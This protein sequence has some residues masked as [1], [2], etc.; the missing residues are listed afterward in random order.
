MICD[1]CIHKELCKT[2]E[3]EHF[4]GADECYFYDK[5]KH[6]HWELQEINEDH[7]Y[8]WVCSECE[9]RNDSLDK[10]NFCPNCGADMRGELNDSD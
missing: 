2:A 1:R 4:Y 5:I 3:F 9:G 6:G 7:E 8:E 10:L